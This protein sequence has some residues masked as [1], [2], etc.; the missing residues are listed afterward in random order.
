[1]RWVLARIGVRNRI[2]APYLSRCH[3]DSQPNPTKPIQL[4][5][6]KT[7]RER[8]LQFVLL[9]STVIYLQIFFISDTKLDVGTIFFSFLNLLIYRY[10]VGQFVKKMDLDW[11]A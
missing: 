11:N 10:S 1:M 4:V 3:F 2:L 8:E 6:I 5:I 9:L 7:K